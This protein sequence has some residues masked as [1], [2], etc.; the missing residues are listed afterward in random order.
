M[1][2]FA[3]E[4]ADAAHVAAESAKADAGGEWTMVSGKQRTPAPEPAPEPTEPKIQ[5]Q[6]GG[7]YCVLGA[8]EETDGGAFPELP[9]VA[10]PQPTTLPK[11]TLRRHSGTTYSSDGNVVKLNNTRS[12]AD[13][14]SDEDDDGPGA[15]NP[16]KVRGAWGR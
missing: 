7:V 14:S 10:R 1:L 2:V 15:V 3:A 4:K 8:D 6:V 11:P 13:Y 9:S 12:W 5:A 16:D